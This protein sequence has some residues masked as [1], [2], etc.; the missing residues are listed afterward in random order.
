MNKW[1]LKI[2]YLPEL[3]ALMFGRKKPS[4]VS[5]NLTEK[6]NQQC[7]Y[8]EIGQD[9]LKNG[10]DCLTKEDLFWIIDQMALNKLTRL[11]MCGGEPFLFP[12]LTDVVAYAWQKNI[13]SNITSNGMIINKLNESDFDVFKVCET[14]INISVDS[15]NNNIQKLTRGNEQA[16]ANAIQSIQILQKEGISI[17]VLSAIS[18]YNFHDLYNSLVE[19][20][21]IGVRQV[22]YQPII[23]YSNFP[24]KTVIKEKQSLNVS[25]ENLNILIEELYKIR[26]F[27][28]THSIT[29]NVYRMLPWISHYINHVGVSD[30]KWFF[31]RILKKFYC[32]ES[33]AVIDI[34]YHGGIQPCGLIKAHINIK[35]NKEKKMLTLWFEATAELKNDLK[36]HKYP[37]VCNGCCH[38]FSRN[39]LASVIKYPFSNRTALRK[40]IPLVLS[41]EISKKYKRE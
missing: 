10:T 31:Q 36:N 5:I 38:K 12:G 33:L 8:C 29:T 9:T 35:K 27:E 23:S 6:C 21:K 28:K 37:L 22:L 39:M 3:S 41:R 13:R 2:N 7:I 14:T 25:P 17:I 16:L 24:D 30:N 20:Y 32:R 19:A 11:S 15:F 34:D 18:K 4:M 40:I 26:K 1:K